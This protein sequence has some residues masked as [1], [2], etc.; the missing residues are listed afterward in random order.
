MLV[1]GWDGK[2][3]KVTWT[4]FRVVDY[5]RLCLSN[6]L[7][8]LF[9]WYCC[10]WSGLDGGLCYLSEGGY[11]GNYGEIVW[12]WTYLKAERRDAFYALA[13]KS[14]TGSDTSL[15]VVVCVRKVL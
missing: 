6:V 7:L 5:V 9:L 8:W 4:Q 1:G 3:H 2:T 12:W 13:A 15:D 11:G 10:V 14:R